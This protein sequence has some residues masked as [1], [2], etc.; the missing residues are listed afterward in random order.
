MNK[1]EECYV[2]GWSKSAHSG[3]GEVHTFW[4]VADAEAEFAAEDKKH[5][6]A[7]DAAAKYVSEYRQP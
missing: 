4:S 7:Y 2:C 5:P 6:P 1:H 3:N